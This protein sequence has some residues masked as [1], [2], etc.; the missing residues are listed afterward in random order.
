M[1]NLAEKILFLTINCKRFGNLRTS[2][3]ELNTTANESW[4]HTNKQLLRSP[5]LAAISKRDAAIKKEI[6]IYL[7]PYKVGCAILPAAS[8]ATVREILESYEK[9]E[10]PQLVK[11]FVDAYVTRIEEAKV[12][13]KEQFDAAQYKDVS[14]V[15]EEFAFD[16]DIMSLV[17]PTDLKEAAHA[18]IMAAADGIADALAAAAYTCTK[19]LAESL[20]SNEDGTAKKIYDKQFLKLQEFLAGFDIRNVT[21]HAGL[22]VEMDLLKELVAGVDP[23]QVRNNDGLRIKLAEKMSAATVALCTMVQPQGRVFREANEPVI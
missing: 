22:K 12:E 17:L 13:Q 20:S 7:L 4:F 11:A 9:V 10:R 8:G 1:G 18:K 2:K 14:E 19:K 5:E 16:Y 6:S 3:V 15:A 23:E 21:N